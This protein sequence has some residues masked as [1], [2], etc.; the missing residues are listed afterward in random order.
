MSA[1]AWILLGMISGLVAAQAVSGTRLGIVFDVVSAISL[2]AVA[3]AVAYRL[4]GGVVVTPFNFWS[5]CVAM[6]TS[7]VLV[8]MHNAF[9]ASHVT[10]FRPRR[11]GPQRLQAG[12]GSPR[13]VQHRNRLRPD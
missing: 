3:G 12:P 4:L 10:I 11:S 5:M 8:A 6:A 2:A 9:M 1:A 13:A 7:V